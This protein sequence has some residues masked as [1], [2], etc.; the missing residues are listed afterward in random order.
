MIT[1]N[2][3]SNIV[4]AI[5]NFNSKGYKT[6]LTARV[7]EGND[8]ISMFGKTSY[9]NPD[10]YAKD[11][12]ITFNVTMD[13]TESGVSAFDAHGSI[14]FVSRFG[15]QP[16]Q[17]T[18]PSKN[19]ILLTNRNGEEF[20]QF[21]VAELVTNFK[22][23]FIERIVEILP[24]NTPLFIKLIDPRENV[25]WEVID[26]DSFEYQEDVA[27]ELKCPGFH[28][29]II[30]QDSGGYK[31]YNADEEFKIVE[32]TSPVSSDG[33]PWIFGTPGKLTVCSH[34]FAQSI[35]ATDHQP[36]PISEEKSELTPQQKAEA[37][38]QKRDEGKSEQISWDQLDHIVN[39]LPSTFPPGDGSVY[40][41][42]VVQ[43]EGNVIAIDFRAKK[44]L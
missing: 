11:G 3:P 1:L 5:N 28:F 21:Q 31:I 43:S 9:V 44:K 18:I 26:C 27:V 30:E 22:L 41:G 29:D 13:A 17:V 39:R 8:L 6:Y 32:I 14:S 10:T 37:V 12:H 38:W 20:V 33:S 35:A 42:H 19:V 40:S 15:G 36:L 25:F 2:T 34:D 16:V 4:E 23:E 24:T 7:R